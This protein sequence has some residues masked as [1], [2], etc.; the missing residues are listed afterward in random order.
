MVAQ[1]PKRDLSLEEALAAG[2]LAEDKRKRVQELIEEEEGA[3]NR[4]GGWLG[5][6]VVAFAVF[7]SVV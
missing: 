5:T 6:S 7:V 1:Q 3:T 2:E 4:L